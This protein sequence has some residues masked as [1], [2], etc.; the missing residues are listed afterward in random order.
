[1][2]TN[3]SK[4]HTNLQEQNSRPRE[5]KKRVL[6]VINETSCQEND[7]NI[8]TWHAWKKLHTETE[9]T[10]SIPVHYHLTLSTK[11]QAN[12]NLLLR[13]TYKIPK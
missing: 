5:K 9:Q 13:S 7:K 10:I 6:Y 8:P 11:E 12:A 4:I 1:M 3:K 2:L